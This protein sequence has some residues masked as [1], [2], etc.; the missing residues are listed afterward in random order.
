MKSQ[1]DAPEFRWF[2]TLC[3]ST[4]LRNPANI[5]LVRKRSPFCFFFP[6]SIRHR[7]TFCCRRCLIA[8]MH[9]CASS[10]SEKRKSGEQKREGECSLVCVC[11]TY[12]PLALFL[13]FL[14]V[15]PGSEANPS[16]HM[17]SLPNSQII[18][19]QYLMGVCYL[20]IL[21]GASLQLSSFK[22]ALAN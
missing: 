1:Y 8:P 12:T 20:P 5:S 19:A 10:M 17:Q 13:Y 7:H 9:K 4:M 15:A 3:S 6:F 11:V 16:S 18:L 21:N 14:P 22:R 2:E